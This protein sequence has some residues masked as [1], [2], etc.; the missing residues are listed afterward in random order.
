[1][2][3]APTPRARCPALV[4]RSSRSTAPSTAPMSASKTK[5]PAAI[6]EGRPSP[7]RLIGASSGLGFELRWALRQHFLCREPVAVE[8]TLGYDLGARPERVGQRRGRQYLDLRAAVG[9]EEAGGQ[10]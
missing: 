7:G 5:T 4:S 2:K 6:S 3:S 9:Y 10:P 8:G 1:M